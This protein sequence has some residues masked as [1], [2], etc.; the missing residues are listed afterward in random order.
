MEA[1]TEARQGW[2]NAR[3]QES[4]ASFVPSEPPERTNLA[5]NTSIADFSLPG[6]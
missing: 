1:E 5:H 3:S 4:A 6:L 2:P